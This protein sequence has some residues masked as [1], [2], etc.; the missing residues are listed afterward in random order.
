MDRSVSTSMPRAYSM[1]LR[2]LVKIRRS[3]HAP[4][5]LEP[6]IFPISPVYQTDCRSGKKAWARL[7]VPPWFPE[8]NACVA[9][10]C[11]SME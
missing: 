4:R 5:A 6:G 9:Y 3:L 7:E 1:H 8:W 11:G 2:L 10:V